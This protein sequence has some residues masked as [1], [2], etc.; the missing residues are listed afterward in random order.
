[1]K[2][3]HDEA[4][5]GTDAFRTFAK[6][7]GPDDVY[8]HIILEILLEELLSPSYNTCGEKTNEAPPNK[9]NISSK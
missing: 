8:T 3:N 4:T 9:Q 2:K 6:E 1:M 7:F 5:A